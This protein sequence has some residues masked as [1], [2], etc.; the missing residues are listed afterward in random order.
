MFDLS[1]TRSTREEKILLVSDGVGVDSPAQP[2]TWVR[3]ALV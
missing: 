1:G 2:P 3:A